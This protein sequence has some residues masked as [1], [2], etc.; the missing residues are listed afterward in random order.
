MRDMTLARLFGQRGNGKNMLRKWS[1]N[2]IRIGLDA[3]VSVESV[4]GFD[5]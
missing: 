2:E 5:N 4:R 1:L 3:C